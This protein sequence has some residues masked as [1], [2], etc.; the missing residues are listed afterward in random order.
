[1]LSCLRWYVDKSTYPPLD[2]LQQNIVQ[3]YNN[4]IANKFL[5]YNDNFCRS[6]R[7]AL[8]FASCTGLSTIQVDNT[9]PKKANEDSLERI[10]EFFNMIEEVGGPSGQFTNCVRIATRKPQVRGG[11]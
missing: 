1:M 9:N 6:S 4:V 11:S 2:I 7:I 10:N 8:P 5:F 3:L